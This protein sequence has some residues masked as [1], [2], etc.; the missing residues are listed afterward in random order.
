MSPIL[1]AVDLFYYR[2]L[3]DILHKAAVHSVEFSKQTGSLLFTRER[4]S[5]EI[6]WNV[7]YD[8]MS[9]YKYLNNGMLLCKFLSAQKILQNGKKP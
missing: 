4:V 5:F 8:K 9:L 3:Y 2:Y 1:L 7:V 6:E